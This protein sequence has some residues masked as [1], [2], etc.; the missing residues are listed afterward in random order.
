MT[1]AMNIVVSEVKELLCRLKVS[2]GRLMKPGI[3]PATAG[4]QGEIDCELFS[5]YSPDLQDCCQ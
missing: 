1:E 4:L 5:S 3:E 2:S